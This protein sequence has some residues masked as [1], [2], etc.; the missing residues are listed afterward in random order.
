MVAEALKERRGK[1]ASGQ[2]CKSHFH[3]WLDSVSKPL[4]LAVCKNM[5]NRFENQQTLN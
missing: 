5:S 1:R 3:T 4:C 2:I